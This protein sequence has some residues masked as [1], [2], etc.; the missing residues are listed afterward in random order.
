MYF[1][2]SDALW[3]R[4]L[5]VSCWQ[6][7]YQAQLCAAAAGPVPNRL[8]LHFYAPPLLPIPFQ[9][10][11][12]PGPYGFPL[13]LYLLNLLTFPRLVYTVLRQRSRRQP[14][15]PPLHGAC[16][17]A[18]GPQD[19]PTLRTE[20]AT[21]HSSMPACLAASVWTGLFLGRDHSTSTTLDTGPK[22]NFCILLPMGEQHGRLPRR[23]WAL[24]WVPTEKAEN[25]SAAGGSITHLCYKIERCQP[26]SAA[27]HP[28][29]VLRFA[30]R[31][32]RR[33][34]TRHS[35]LSIRLALAPR[36]GGADA[37]VRFAYWT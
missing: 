33:C 19:A 25:H 29:V 2:Y 26:Y 32:T 31:C 5:R 34:V 23:P 13:N 24:A 12:R 20:H 21:H 1:Y 4:R 11:P 17:P 22:H 9:T 35:T 7:L 37:G 36:R 15:T 30:W 28:P 10:V 16:P 14:Q 8:R 6:G 27:R 3:L 18:A